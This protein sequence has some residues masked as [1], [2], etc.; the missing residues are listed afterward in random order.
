MNMM[1]LNKKNILINN[2]FLRTLL[3]TVSML[4]CGSLFAVT[5]Y[6]SAADGDWNTAANWTGGFLILEGMQI[7]LQTLP[8]T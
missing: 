5:T 2:K 3:L 7:T 1:H 4:L 8:T 6:D